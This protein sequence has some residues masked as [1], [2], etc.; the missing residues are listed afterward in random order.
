M[1]EI[2]SGE[3]PL[4]GSL[5]KHHA[6]ALECLGVT[7]GDGVQVT[8][9]LSKL[10]ISG[11]V[12]RRELGG[13]RLDIAQAVD[14]LVGVFL[15]GLR[16]PINIG[17]GLAREA[18]GVLE[19]VGGVGGVN[20][21][22]RDVRETGCQADS[23]GDGERPGG[24]LPNLLESPTQA[25]DDAALSRPSVDVPQGLLELLGDRLGGE[26]HLDPGCADG[27]SR[28]LAASHSGPPRYAGRPHSGV[29]RGLPCVGYALAW[30][31]SSGCLASHRSPLASCRSCASLAF[32]CQPGSG[33]CGGFGRSDCLAPTAD[34][35]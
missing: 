13:D 23:A 5:G 28:G 19:F 25:G 16:E 4:T 15:R 2:L 1:V 35:M 17:C 11:D 7:A 34:A 27:V 10:V 20:S 9:G 30:A 21:L 3:F 6:D 24:D 22:L 18:Q 32:C 26:G 31:A 29:L 8:G 12:I 33:G 14:G